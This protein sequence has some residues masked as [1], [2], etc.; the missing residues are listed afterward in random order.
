V[1]QAID[2]IRFTFR[3]LHAGTTTTAFSV[4]G[5]GYS[6]AGKKVDTRKACFFGSHVLPG[7][8]PSNINLE[9]FYCTG[10]VARIAGLQP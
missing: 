6:G 8:N 10:D 4:F 2:S 1:A 3:L 7:F 9:L 5:A